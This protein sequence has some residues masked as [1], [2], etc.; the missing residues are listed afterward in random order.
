MHKAVRSSLA[1][2][3]SL[4]LSTQAIAVGP[5]TV[6]TFD[7]LDLGTFLNVS[8]PPEY[9]GV[10]WPD[11]MG[12]YSPP[13]PPYFPQSPPNR[14]LFNRYDE[15]GVSESIVTFVGGP[16][17]FDGAYFSGFSDVRFTLYSGG[18]LVSESSTLVLGSSGSGP[19]FLASGYPSPVDQVG[20][21]GDRSYF[22]MDN[23]TFE[24]VPEPST[25]LLLAIGAIS[26]LGYRKAK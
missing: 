8:I 14:V 15:L 7:D 18:V 23:F 25:L 6:L 1:I 16:K 2:F 24:N 9:G 26:L 11:N 4:A 10:S 5:P 17:I 20:I 13:E 22:A 3:L 12:L 19:T 21:I